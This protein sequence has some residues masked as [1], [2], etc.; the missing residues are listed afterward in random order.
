MGDS[1]NGETAVQMKD[2]LCAGFERARLFERTGQPDHS[3]VRSGRPRLDRCGS[4]GAVGV[5]GALRLRCFAGSLRVARSSWAIWRRDADV[6]RPDRHTGLR[7][8]E[9]KDLAIFSVHPPLRRAYRTGRTLPRSATG[10]CSRRRPVL[11]RNAKPFTHGFLCMLSSC[12]QV[13]PNN[14]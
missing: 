3:M 1:W 8:I 14:G 13:A 2:P 4:L 10:V 6:G 12:V 5:L 9:T 11:Q 7:R